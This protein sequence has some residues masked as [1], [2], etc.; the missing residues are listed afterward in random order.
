MYPTDG[1]RCR[2][3]GWVGWQGEG[4]WF[5][6]DSGSAAVETA[7]TPG[8]PN[9]ECTTSRFPLYDFIALRL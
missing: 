8:R 5:V 7:N 3:M 2:W 9:H 6:R 1:T 4:D